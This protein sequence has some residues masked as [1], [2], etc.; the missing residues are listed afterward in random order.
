[1]FAFR[2]GL[3]GVGL[4]LGLA[5]LS[6]RAVLGI[7]QH[8]VGAL[9]GLGD[10]RLGGVTGLGED[11]VCVGAGV[12]QHLVGFGLGG[13]GEPVG[14]VLRQGQN[15]G[16]LHGLLFV[17]SRRRRCYRRRRRRR[18][19]RLG[20]GLEGR[21]HLGGLSAAAATGGQLA[22]QLLDPLTQIG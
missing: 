10:R 7:G 12:G 4:L 13:A 8:R 5:Q 20:F 16:G 3:Q 19:D 11:L 9:P 6:L 21:D 17:G 18:L 1:M 14:G 22:V 2:V 15:P